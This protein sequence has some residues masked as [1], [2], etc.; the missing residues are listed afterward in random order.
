MGKHN[1]IILTII[2]HHLIILVYVFRYE[3]QSRFKHDNNNYFNK[4][5]NIG[6]FFL[7][8]VFNFKNAVKFV[9]SQQK[10]YH[11]HRLP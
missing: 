10:L 3:I 4:S 11:C 5:I 1:H 9:Q 6:M 7:F 8:F 2:K